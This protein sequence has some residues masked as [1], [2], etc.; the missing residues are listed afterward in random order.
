MTK[1]GPHDGL[2]VSEMTK[3]GLHDGLRVSEMTKQGLHDGLGVSEMTKQGL[4]DGLRVSEMIKQ[5]LHNDFGVSEMIKQGLHNDFG[6][7][8]GSKCKGRKSFAPTKRRGGTPSQSLINRH[9]LGAF[10]HLD[11]IH[12]LRQGDRRLT[13]R[14]RDRADEHTVEVYRHLPVQPSGESDKAF[15]PQHKCAPRGGRHYP[16]YSPKSA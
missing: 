13:C 16:R 15:H 1:Q 2:R 3:Q 6:V 8:F 9:L 4:Y 14:R 10:A 11:D 12:A 5:G 7:F